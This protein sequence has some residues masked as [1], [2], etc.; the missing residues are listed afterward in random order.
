MDHCE[1][2]EQINSL[3]EFDSALFT[4]I[5]TKPSVIAAAAAR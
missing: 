4:Q 3:E 5:S 2:P 1:P